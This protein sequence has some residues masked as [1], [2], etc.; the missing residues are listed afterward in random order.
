M[1]A[2]KKSPIPSSRLYKFVMQLDS[3]LHT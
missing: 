2:K 1:I 3:K